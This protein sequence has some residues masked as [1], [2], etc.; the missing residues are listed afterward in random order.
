MCT[1]TH[2]STG[3][4][5]QWAS[6]VVGREEGTRACIPLFYRLAK[7]PKNTEYVTKLLSGLLN[8]IYSKSFCTACLVCQNREKEEEGAKMDIW[9]VLSD[10]RLTLATGNVS[11]WLYRAVGG[12]NWEGECWCECCNVLNI[13]VDGQM[14]PYPQCSGI[15]SQLNMVLQEGD[16]F[17]PLNWKWHHGFPVS[18][19]NKLPGIANGGLAILITDNI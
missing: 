9:I 15:F 13:W 17:Q 10:T 11:L 12:K 14:L 4:S 19:H 18:A 8:T 7:Q 3:F 5:S 1:D 6:G 16:H 2:H